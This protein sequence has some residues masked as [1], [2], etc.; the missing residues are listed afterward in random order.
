[1]HRQVERR[2]HSG[3]CCAVRVAVGVGGVVDDITWERGSGWLDWLAGWLAGWH[4]LGVG[5]GGVVV[6]VPST[7]NVH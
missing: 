3:A 2:G 7:Y 6:H 5:P 1:M 4:W